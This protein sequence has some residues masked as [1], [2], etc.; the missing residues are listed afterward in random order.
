MEGSTKTRPRDP[1]ARGGVGMEAWAKFV[2]AH[3]K[4]FC[5]LD[6]EL[7]ERENLAVGDYDVLIQLSLAPDGL[8][9]CELAEA[10]VLSPSG[11]TRRVARLERAG[12]VKRERA[13]SDARSIEARLTPA[14]KKLFE[15]SRRTH[16]AGIKRLFIDHFD[17]DELERLSELF[18]RLTGAEEPTGESC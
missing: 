15:R 13:A 7:R 10:V 11:L 3:S 6:A 12:L 8:R 17:D 16:R 5:E 4:L 1:V 2:V 14:G 9:M 18:G